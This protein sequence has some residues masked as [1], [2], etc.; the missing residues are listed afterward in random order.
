[1]TATGLTYEERTALLQVL[2]FLGQIAADGNGATVEVGTRENDRRI[3]GY[4][5]LVDLEDEANPGDVTDEHIRTLTRF[6]NS[7]RARYRT[8]EGAA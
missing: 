2:D 4:R 5:L 3:G 8:L 7:D 6:L 1:M